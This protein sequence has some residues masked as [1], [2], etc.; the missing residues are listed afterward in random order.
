M[1]EKRT[2]ATEGDP[3][4]LVKVPIA[5]ALSNNRPAM[6]EAPPVAPKDRPSTA[7]LLSASGLPEDAVHDRDRYLERSILGEGGMGRIHL[8][9]DSRVGRDVAM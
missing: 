9:H 1:A 3:V 7:D 8:C 2:T 6:G 4:T 5:D